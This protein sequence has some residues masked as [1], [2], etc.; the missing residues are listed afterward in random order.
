MVAVITM[1]PTGTTSLGGPPSH[2]SLSPGPVTTWV[3]LRWQVVS[4]ASMKALMQHYQAAGFLKEGSR[5]EDPKQAECTMTVGFASLTGP[6]DKQLICW[7]PQPL[8]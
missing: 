4:S 7:V 5:L 8:K 1:V 6:R 3:G 2:H